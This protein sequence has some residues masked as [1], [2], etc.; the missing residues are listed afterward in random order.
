MAIAIANGV[1]LSYEVYGPEEAPA[2]LFTH[3]AGWDHRQWLPQVEPFSRHYRVI[4]WDVRFHGR[5]GCCDLADL[6]DFS[7]DQMA[8]LD[9][10]GVEQAVLVGCSM[11]GH[12]SLRTAILYPERVAALVLMGTPVTSAY[13]WRNRLAITLQEGSLKKFFSEL[14]DIS[15]Q[16]FS[17]FFYGLT[18][19]F[20]TMEKIASMHAKGLSLFH[21]DLEE[22]FYGVT[23]QHPKERWN[24]IWEI[25][26]RM[27]TL[28]D[29]SKVACPTLV[30]E[31][32]A[33]WMMRRQHRFICEAIPQA[34]HRLIPDA[35]HATN[36]DNPE[37]VNDCI[38]DFLRQTLLRDC[39]QKQRRQLAG[40]GC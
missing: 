13:N 33:D 12:I 28:A 8:L 9:H 19:R 21:P 34:C 37:A 16:G 40:A 36:L 35:G 39:A 27:E 4:L 11:G 31:G 3:G 22:Y 14:I 25:A 17:F 38:A 23:V 2:L 5:S 7:R 24:L 30:I 6:D 26:C 20:A 18:L 29:L 10:L 1:R 15:L 32:D